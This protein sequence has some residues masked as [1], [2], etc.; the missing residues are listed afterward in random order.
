MI[1]SAT[2]AAAAVSLSSIS[3]I[4]NAQSVG[5]VEIA[6]LDAKSYQRLTY[7]AFEGSLGGSRNM[8]R[9]PAGKVFVVVW[10]ELKLKPGKDEDGDDV[11]VLERDDNILIDEKGKKYGTVGRCSRDGR[12]RPGES[13]F[14][15]YPNE[16]SPP[17][18]AYDQVFAVPQ[19]AKNVTLKIVDAEKKFAMPANVLPTIDPTQ[20]ATFK[21]Q[22]AR[23]VTK[24]EQKYELGTFDKPEG[25]ATIEAEATASKFLS[26]KILVQ[27]KAN[28]SDDGF[29][30][31]GGDFG[32]LLG[33]EVYVPP[34]GQIDFDGFSS[35]QAYLSSEA[36]K[37]GKFEETETTLIF[38]LPGRIKTFQLLYRTRQVANG[39]IAP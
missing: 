9:P 21:I 36:D 1:R 23:V 2:L 3:T 14:Y 29:V 34:I 35:D 18:V 16:D 38:P 28:N 32:L 25:E 20:I 6:K 37:T 4:A 7:E 8:M 30:A 10:M 27:P 11:V 31:N 17:L 19:S 12:F 39:T 5:G 24:L 13:G 26:L 15:F 33:K 22:Q